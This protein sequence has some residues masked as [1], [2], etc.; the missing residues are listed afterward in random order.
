MCHIVGFST[1]GFLNSFGVMQSYYVSFLGK[2]PSDISWIGSILGFLLFFVSAFSGRL[3]DA[4]YFHQTI[5]TGTALQL[6]GIF[7]ASFSTNYWQLVLSHGICVGLGGGLIF[8]PAPS[9]VVTCFVK[10]R[11]LALA[12]CAC[13]NSVGGL[14]YADVLQNRLPH[15]GFARAM[16][17]CG[18]V[19]AAVI[20]PANILLK[21]RRVKRESAP[22][23]EWAAF[24]EPAYSF[25]SV[26]MFLCM[27]GQWVP[28]FY[29]GSFGRDIIGITTHDASSLLL[30][31][32]GVGVAGWIVPAFLAP[33]YAPMNLMIPLSL[34][35]GLIL[36]AW[37]AVTNHSG[38]LV[39]DVFYGVFM[40]A[41]QGMLPLSLGSLTSD[42][43]KMGVRI[44]MVFSILGFAILI[45]NP[46]AG[47]LISLD[48]GKY[49]YAQMYAGSVL[50]VGVV[51][52]AAARVIVTGWRLFVR[53]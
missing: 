28:V 33:V 35:A 5:A 25:F 7:G 39:F 10:N 50:A 34:I 20:I 13:G 15:L 8:I 51:F 46:L 2:S 14:F 41:A 40:T 32:N 52:L 42:L 45:G 47:A 12:L 31:I 3:T 4:G 21:P 9:L 53:V 38:I 23:V 43:S 44:G 1:W 6:L 48:G 29:L 49:L 19:M 24:K 22:L 36:L 17:V 18:F 27:L 16:R 11:S 30:L 26:G 37:V